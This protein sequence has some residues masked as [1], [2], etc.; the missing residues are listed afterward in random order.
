MVCR[1]RGDAPVARCSA[2]N[3]A[4]R[5]KH[6][7]RF[8]AWLGRD[9][10]SAPDYGRKQGGKR[11]CGSGMRRMRLSW[12]RCCSGNPLHIDTDCDRLFDPE[13]LYEVGTDPRNPDTDGDGIVDGMAE[14]GVPTWLARS[15]AD[16]FCV[17][18]PSSNG[19]ATEEGT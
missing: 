4:S 19:G 1:G 5:S 11:R 9:A 8:R 16:P 13:E 10:G 2:E 6:T 17:P 3:S 18:T 7:I 15:L 12:C 14:R